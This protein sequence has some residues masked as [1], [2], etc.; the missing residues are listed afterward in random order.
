VIFSQAVTIS[1]P[2]FGQ[3]FPIEAVLER[4]ARPLPQQTPV[5][6]YI[7][8]AFTN[9]T[10]KQGWF[11]MKNAVA[12]SALA[13]FS[14]LAFAGARTE[15]NTLRKSTTNREFTKS[16]LSEVKKE[17]CST[18]LTSQIEL[19]ES[20]SFSVIYAYASTVN[21]SCRVEIPQSPYWPGYP[22]LEA[23]CYGK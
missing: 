4:F 12:L 9:V 11:I 10:F 22:N 18:A 21:C 3:A 13:L 7:H 14:S 6:C 8:R 20:R 1:G 23:I 15:F 16:V 5:Q 19:D 2:H 17:G